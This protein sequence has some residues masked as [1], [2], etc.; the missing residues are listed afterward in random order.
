MTTYANILICIYI[1]IYIC[2]ST[3][4]YIYTYICIH[5]QNIDF[6]GAIWANRIISLVLLRHAIG[7]I[8]YWRGRKGKHKCWKQNLDVETIVFHQANIEDPPVCG[9]AELWMSFFFKMFPVDI[10]AKF[11]WNWTKLWWLC[12]KSGENPMK[13]GWNYGREC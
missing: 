11:W 1:Y 9:K 12:W 2:T 10:L 7:Q 3:Y 6:G 8:R 13:F 5:I 4:I